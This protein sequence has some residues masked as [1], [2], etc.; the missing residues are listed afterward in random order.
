[1]KTDV[2]QPLREEGI[3]RTRI[4]G[5]NGEHLTSAH[6][7]TQS[8]FFSLLIFRNVLFNS[9]YLHSTTLTN[10]ER[11]VLFKTPA[12]FFKHMKS[13]TAKYN[14]EGKK[15]ETYFCNK[16]ALS[17]QPINARSTASARKW[18]QRVYFSPRKPRNA[19]GNYA[20]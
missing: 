5:R 13:L 3:S 1:M 17:Q 16:Q 8:G 15:Q 20:T 10:A 7:C 14:I 12:E 9:P 11:R 2:L 18:Q 19:V 6:A 4:N